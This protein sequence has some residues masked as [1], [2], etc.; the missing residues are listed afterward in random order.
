[1]EINIEKTRT[2]RKHSSNGKIHVGVDANAVFNPLK[3]KGG[4]KILKKTIY[5][6]GI[7]SCLLVLITFTFF[8][9]VSCKKTGELITSEVINGNEISIPLQN[10]P[11]TTIVQGDPDACVDSFRLRQ[12]MVITDSIGWKNLIKEFV[13]SG[14]PYTTVFG[15]LVKTE[16]DFSTYQIIAVFDKIHSS[17]TH[18][19]DI[20]AIT[21]YTDK[22]IVNV[23]YFTISH[24]PSV[25]TRPYHIVKIQRSNKKIVFQENISKL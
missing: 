11:F 7:L 16:I 17:G 9:F 13:P 4:F 3:K 15:I 6:S 20:T 19:T 23:S 18:K 1:M 21:E 8:V 10:I 14:Y 25:V 24:G 12:N 22:I 5:Y 2:G